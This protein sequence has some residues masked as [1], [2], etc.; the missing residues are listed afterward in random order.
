MFL[1]EIKENENKEKLAKTKS[2]RLN[3]LPNEGFLAIFK[4]ENC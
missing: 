1:F 4:I 2:S 3:V